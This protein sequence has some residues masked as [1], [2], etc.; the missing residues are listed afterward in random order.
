MYDQLHWHW[1]WAAIL[2]P[3]PFVLPWLWPRRAGASTDDTAEVGQRT[4]LLHPDV[5][6]LA[7]TYDGQR[8]RRV[9]A[10][11]LYKALM[12][13]LWAA[14]VV[15][16]MRPQWLVPHTEVST[17]GYDLMVAVDASRSMNALDF[18]R[19]GREVTRMQVVKGVMRRF[20]EGRVGDRVGLVVFGARA[21]V[22]SPLTIDRN[23]VVQLLGTLEAR[24]AGDSTALGD[25]IALGVKKLR[26]RPEG[27]RVM[28]LL[29]DGDNSAGGFLPLEAA[30]LARRFGVRIYVVGVGS[31]RDEIPIIWDEGQIKYDT[32]LTL[33]EDILRT[34]ATRT[35][36]AYFRAT[37]TD[38]L[39]DISNKID[40]LE[41]TQAERRTAFLPTPLYRIPLGV[42]GLA[43]LALG[44][45]PEGRRRFAK[46]VAS[47]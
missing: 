43:L 3:L 11:L 8:P 42:A 25:A 2:L 17:P 46:R 26:D 14:L 44:L 24:V 22:L 10:G 9:L 45:F 35:G 39:E 47:G 28:I 5:A 6:A 23:A 1:P 13:V 37:D 7:A 4:T 33:D 36:G 15:S 38:A 12:Y 21:Y 34:I 27:S 19:S 40:A 31:K 20:V 30:E 41:K 32:G 16:L 29:A 18:T